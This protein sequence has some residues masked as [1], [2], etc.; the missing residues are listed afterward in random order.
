MLKINDL[1]IPFKQQRLS[2]WREKEDSTI[3]YLKEAL[4]RLRSKA[5]GW[6][7]TCHINKKQKKAGVVILISKW[8]LEKEILPVIKKH[9]L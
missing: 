6:E 5:K 7:K 9:I 2:G 1:D 4:Y 8:N 3:Q